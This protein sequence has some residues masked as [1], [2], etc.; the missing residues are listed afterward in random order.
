MEECRPRAR[1]FGCANAWLQ[2]IRNEIVKRRRVGKEWEVVVMRTQSINI[3]D[4][5]CCVCE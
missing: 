2:E 4:C 5:V 1:R 3:L